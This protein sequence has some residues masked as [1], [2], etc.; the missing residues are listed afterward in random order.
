MK[1]I[2]ISYAKRNSSVGYWQGM[3]YLAGMIVRVIDDE[4]EA[5]WTFW[6]LFEWIL[7]LDYF[8]LMTE[9]LI[10]QKVFIHLVQ[11]HKK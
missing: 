10:D 1:W 5:F 9:I 6:N 8:C 11:K 4:E 2:L 3:N 7:P